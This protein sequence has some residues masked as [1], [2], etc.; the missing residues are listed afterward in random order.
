MPERTQFKRKDG[1]TVIISRN[2]MSTKRHVCEG[3]PK[4]KDCD[5]SC[6]EVCKAA[7]AEKK[8]SMY[9]NGLGTE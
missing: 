8:F 1:T 5:W 4:I 2:R 9:E 3:C 7:E 6:L